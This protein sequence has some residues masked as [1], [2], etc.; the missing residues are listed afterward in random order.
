[1]RMIFSYRIFTYRGS[2]Y[3]RF[4]FESNFKYVVK[5]FNL[6]NL[7]PVFDTV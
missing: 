1:M 2:K 6:V 3:H 4:T 7:L 5:Q